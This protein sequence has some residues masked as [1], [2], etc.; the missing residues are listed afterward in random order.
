MNIETRIR[1]T[2]YLTLGMTAP[3]L[4]YLYKGITAPT[5]VIIR[6]GLCFL[7]SWFGLGILHR[8][9]V[10]MAYDRARDLIDSSYVEVP[11]APRRRNADKK[12]P[13]P[14]DEASAAAAVDAVIEDLQ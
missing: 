6:L 3:S 11:I 9:I 7:A 2:F 10:W 14:V 5:E 8:F 4:W 13:A 1:W 12:A